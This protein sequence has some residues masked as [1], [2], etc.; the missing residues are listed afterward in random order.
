[1][2]KKYFVKYWK[3]AKKQLSLLDMKMTTPS[4]LIKKNDQKWEMT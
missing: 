1:M 4:I 3:S 2:K